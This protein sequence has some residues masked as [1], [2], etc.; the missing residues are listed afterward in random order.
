MVLGF[1]IR[2]KLILTRN[3]GSFRY[4]NITIFILEGVAGITLTKLNPGL[5]YLTDLKPIL[6]VSEPVM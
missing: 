3:F 5:G 2:D 4:L 6:I 1:I